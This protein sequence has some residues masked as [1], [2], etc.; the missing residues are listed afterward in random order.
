MPQSEQSF[1]QVTKSIKGGTSAGGDQANPLYQ[2]QQSGSKLLRFQD[3]PRA[4]AKQKLPEEISN[5]AAPKPSRNSNLHK[6]AQT[7]MNSI[8][9]SKHSGSNADLE[10][11]CENSYKHRV[12]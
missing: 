9:E 1:A 8:A 11:V 2:S 10:G 4:L 3:D 6:Q 5:A 7:L 12:N